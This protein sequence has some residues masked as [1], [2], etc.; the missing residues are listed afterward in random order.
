MVMAMMT[1]SSPG[2]ENGDDGQ[3]HDD[4]RESQEHVHDTL[5]QQVETAA[6]VGA[7]NAQDQAGQGAHGCRR[8]TDHQRRPGAID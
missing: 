2:P 6:E 5:E 3:R 4:Q 8:E 1:F 7:G